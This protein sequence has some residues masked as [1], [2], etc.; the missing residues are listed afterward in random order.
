MQQCLEKHR[1]ASPKEL[2]IWRVGGVLTA[3]PAALRL[4]R[5]ACLHLPLGTQAVS[6]MFVSSLWCLAGLAHSEIIGLGGVGRRGFGMQL[7]CT[8]GFYPSCVMHS[9]A[10]SCQKQ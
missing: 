10:A 6:E 5:R 3:P 1:Q 4:L 9:Q 7:G 8:R 2:G